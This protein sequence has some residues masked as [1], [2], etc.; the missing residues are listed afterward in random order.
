MERTLLVT[1]FVEK[2]LE[3]GQK[4]QILQTL[5]IAKILISH[6]PWPSAVY[7]VRGLDRAKIVT[8]RK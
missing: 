4:A 2:N 6:V 7:T 5:E 3:F 1:Y 8:S